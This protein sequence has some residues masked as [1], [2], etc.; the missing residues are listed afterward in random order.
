MKVTVEA[1]RKKINEL[2]D[3]YAEKVHM[4]GP[5]VAEVESFSHLAPEAK[6]GPY[7]VSIKPH[8]ND[9]GDKT[10]L[11]VVCSCTAHSLCR[12]IA[13]FYAVAKGLA[14]QSNPPAPENEKKKEA[15]AMIAEAQK[16]ASE[17]F[18]LLTDGIA[19]YVKE[20]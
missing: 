7:T 19:L 12:H 2:P 17:A 8:K 14:P 1:I 18:Q 10:V 3:G 4:K 20:N 13:A 16:K 5:G 11:D 6:V 15:L 9:P